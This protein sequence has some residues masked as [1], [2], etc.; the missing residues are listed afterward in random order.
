M[1]AMKFFRCL[2]TCL[3]CLL[4]LFGFGAEGYSVLAQLPEDTSSSSSTETES[5]TS[6]FSSSA[7][8]S[9][10]PSSSASS[11]STVSD[12]QPEQPAES[13]AAQTSSSASSGTEQPA[14]SQAQESSQVES[15]MS[16]AVSSSYGVSSRTSSQTD[17]FVPSP[18]WSE[19]LQNLLERT[20]SYL[21]RSDVEECQLYFLAMGSAG[22]N[23]SMAQ[24]TSFTA[25]LT[26]TEFAAEST[27][28]Q[29]YDILNLTFCGYSALNFQGEDLITLLCSVSNLSS[30]TPEELCYCLLALDSNQYD[31]PEG[32]A[33][34]RSDLYSCLLECQQEDGGF[35]A[36]SGETS[37]TYLTG[38]ALT[39][40]APYQNQAQQVSE[41]VEK[42]LR[43]LSE[44][45]GQNGV[46]LQ[47]GTP[48]C[49][50]TAQAITALCSLNLDLRDSKFVKQGQTLLGGL[51]QFAAASGGF[52]ETENASAVQLEAT[53]AAVLALTAM[54]KNASPYVLEVSLGSGDSASQL[55]EE[56][57]QNDS[58]WIWVVSIAGGVLLIGAG[59][60]FLWIRRRRFLR[61]PAPI[62][63]KTDSVPKEDLSDKL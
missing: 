38:L 36:H 25:G 58:L 20:C 2:G 37:D 57:T 12:S 42:G 47:N 21:S 18:Y 32:A 41:A 9:S 28:Q 49:Q 15:T 48:S 61:K 3:L 10:L 40:L 63:S 54:K 13:S 29:A 39:A 1:M 43:F 55:Q 46:V 17:Q 60:V 19:D 6:S 45:Q 56:E 26:E 31:I 53:Q 30:L 22:A 35:S 59:T 24:V 33:F 50:A 16:S 11:D 62:P 4:I 27:L 44:Q 23:V 52:Y 51:Q 7:A 14:S 5:Q 34:S 8:S